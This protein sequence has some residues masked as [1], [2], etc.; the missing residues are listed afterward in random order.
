MWLIP[1]TRLRPIKPIADTQISEGTSVA[2]KP[3]EPIS[4]GETVAAI[5]KPVQ[6]SSEVENL[7]AVVDVA[8]VTLAAAGDGVRP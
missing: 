5:L 7:S 1:P 4:E 8:R 6:P 3:V 2:T